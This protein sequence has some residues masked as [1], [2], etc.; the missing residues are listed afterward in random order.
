MIKNKQQQE[1][2]LKSVHQKASLTKSSINSKSQP[3]LSTSNSNLLPLP[4][5]SD[6][7][8]FPSISR[9]YSAEFN[10]EK[11]ALDTLLSMS[12]LCL[13]EDDSKHMEGTWAYNSPRT[14]PKLKKQQQQHHMKQMIN[15]RMPAFPV[16]SPIDANIGSPA[17]PAIV[18]RLESKSDLL[19]DPSAKNNYNALIGMYREV[20]ADD[21]RKRR[22][23]ETGNPESPVKGK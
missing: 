18:K 15:V 19:S 11:V 13:D 3:L 20:I 21:R 22:I 7:D 10:K 1:A 2:N 4:S 17:S 8:E 16:T 5:T 6:S 23:I 12:S 14:P 9:R